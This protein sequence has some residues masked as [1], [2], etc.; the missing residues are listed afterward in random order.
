MWL[1]RE[2]SLL[3]T[4]ARHVPDEQPL[5]RYNDLPM[6]ALRGYRGPEV[7][8]AKSKVEGALRAKDF[9]Q[10]YVADLEYRR[11]P[12]P[13]LLIER[14]IGRIMNMVTTSLAVRIVPLV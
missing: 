1:S 12:I 14:D 8:I 13:K 10:N 5:V 11:S 7:M 2:S 3:P 4:P 6:Y 9:I